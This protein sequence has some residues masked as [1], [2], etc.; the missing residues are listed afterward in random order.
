MDAE[1]KER[2]KAQGVD[3]WLSSGFS[4]RLDAEKRI[5]GM[6]SGSGDSDVSRLHLYTLVH[7]NTSFSCLCVHVHELHFFT[8]RYHLLWAFQGGGAE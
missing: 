1:K 3:T 6:D 2:R 5:H 7:G 8:T 4:A